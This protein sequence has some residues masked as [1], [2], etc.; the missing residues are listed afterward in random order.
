M[1]PIYSQHIISFTSIE[2]LYVYNLFHALIVAHHVRRTRGMVN[3]FKRML[4]IFYHP[5]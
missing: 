4:Q 3:F 1:T 2:L 5:E